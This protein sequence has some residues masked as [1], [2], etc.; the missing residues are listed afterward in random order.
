MT[1]K[2]NSLWIIT[3]SQTIKHTN[4]PSPSL[5]KRGW[6]G[7][8]QSG[9]A[10][11]IALIMMVVLTLMGIAASFTSI[12]EIMISGHKRGTTNAFYSA[13]SGI[14]VVIANIDNFNL[15]NKY[16][17]N[18]YNPF[19]DSNNPNPSQARVTI[20][21]NMAQQGSPIGL[22]FS[23]TGNYEFQHFLIESTG[24]DQGGSGDN[25]SLC[26]I[27]QKV[28]RLIPTL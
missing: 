16:I 14:Q 23:A 19:T 10:L 2:A 26:T 20:T 21:Y 22:G 27:E 7:G 1:E 3:H 9:A 18:K 17:N 13:D 12:L 6:R 8:D 5:G 15:T 24:E 28:V 4:S 11:V 25:R